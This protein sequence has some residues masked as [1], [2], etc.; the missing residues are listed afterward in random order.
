MKTMYILMMFI[1]TSKDQTS[2]I[3][4]K[5]GTASRFIVHLLGQI[6]VDC[7]HTQSPLV[8]FTRTSFYSRIN[9]PDFFSTK[10]QKSIIT[11]RF[12]ILPD[13]KACSIARAQ[14]K[15]RKRTAEWTIRNVSSKFVDMLYPPL[16][17]KGT[18]QK[19]G[20]KQIHQIS[21]AGS[22]C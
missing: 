8:S 13:F 6:F 1:L 2:T 12:K 5:D 21:S 9:H 15:F 10:N 11:F 14:H 18:P 19:H 7:N 17:K 3:I 4:I 16:P 22:A 20:A